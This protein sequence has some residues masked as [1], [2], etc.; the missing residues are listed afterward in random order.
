MLIW[1]LRQF[2]TRQEVLQRRRGEPAEQSHGED[3][4][5]GDDRDVFAD[6]FIHVRKDAQKRAF[7]WRTVPRSTGAPGFEF[8]RL[9]QPTAAK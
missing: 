1:P 3:G 9:R 7:G 8:R 2:R 4:N 6:C 5:H